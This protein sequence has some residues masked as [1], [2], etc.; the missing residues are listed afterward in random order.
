MATPTV[1]ESPIINKPYD[2]PEWHWQRHEDG[3][4]VD[5]PKQPNRYPATGK[6]PNINGLNLRTSIA[7]ALDM[8]NLPTELD[9]V[10][11]I[12]HAVQ[13]WEKQGFPYTTAITRDLIGHWTDND[14][15]GLYFAQKEAILTAIWLGEAADRTEEGQAILDEIDRINTAINDGIPRIC[16]QM[17]TGTGK[18][19]VI[20]AIILWQTCNHAK[21]PS[22]IRFTNNFLAIGPGITVRERLNSG[23]QHQKNGK[24]NL[25]SEYINPQLNLVPTAYENCLQ[26]IQF[27]AINF[28][29]FIPR[30]STGDIP[31]RV[32]QFAQ[33]APQLESEDEILDDLVGP[34]RARVMV[35]ND[36]AHHCHKG[37]PRKASGNSAGD[38]DAGIWF[39]GLRLLKDHGLIHGNVYDL[40]ATRSF[41]ATK[42][43]PLF[44]W[45]ISQYPLREAEEAG[46]VKIM[47]LPH[48]EMRPTD[49]SDHL[50]SNIY[51]ATKDAKII[52]REDD[53][54]NNRDLKSA[55]QMMYQD[56][57]QKRRSP[58]WSQ[59]SVPPVIAVIAN[60]VTNA[61]SIY[62][63]I[64]GWERDET[65]HP[66][67]LGSVSH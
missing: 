7:R 38:E 20:A 31:R 19:A 51:A 47:R 44:P 50:A 63:Y 23:L 34:N 10:N 22:D 29:Q 3:R 32:K 14:R 46:I 59:R 39:N 45:I 57:D 33:I 2:P 35:F 67:R 30:D 42:D 27:K 25:N 9:M 64:G 37:D 52:T 43:T 60:T 18:T 61:N 11:D 53:D 24:T 6:L 55:L 62:D 1:K 66:G 40:S 8:T 28:H 65:L 56:W 58:K 36:E 5:A 41:I 4:I 49:W 26:H 48:N 21:R 12:R 17:A 16:H 15:K 13:E 54:G